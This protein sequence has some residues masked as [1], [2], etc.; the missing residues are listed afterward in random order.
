M[1]GP[2][3]GRAGDPQHEP[4][5]VA[6][7]DRSGLAAPA[8]PRE[9]SERVAAVVRG[10]KALRVGRP[11]HDPAP[12]ITPCAEASLVPPPAGPPLPRRIPSADAVRSPGGTGNPTPW[13]E[14]A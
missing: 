4:D 10:F 1:G 2:H 8:D 12:R 6:T 9:V 7:P 13:A 11:V 5:E 14:G 3:Q